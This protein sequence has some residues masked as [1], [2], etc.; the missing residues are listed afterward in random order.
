MKL[1]KSIEIFELG[2]KLTNKENHVT[3]RK[4]Q[5]VRKKSMHAAG[6]IEKKF[7]TCT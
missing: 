7:F 5:K 3:F 4:V 1:R 6:K 2:G